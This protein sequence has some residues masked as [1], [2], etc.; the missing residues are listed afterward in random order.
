MVGM[1]LVV[2]LAVAVGVFENRDLAR[3]CGVCGVGVFENK[4]LARGGVFGG[5]FDIPNR[6]PGILT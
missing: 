4:D 3:G 1:L 5:A 2:L 6:V